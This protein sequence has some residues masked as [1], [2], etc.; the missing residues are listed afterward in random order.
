MHSWLDLFEHAFIFLIVPP[1]FSEI[2][3]LLWSA[4]SINVVGFSNLIDLFWRVSDSLVDFKS[5]WSRLS[6]L[7]RRSFQINP[8]F[9]NFVFWAD[10]YFWINWIFRHVSSASGQLNLL[11]WSSFFCCLD[12]LGLSD[13]QAEPV[14]IFYSV[15]F[16][17][18]FDLFELIRIFGSGKIASIEVFK[19]VKP[20]RPVDSVKS[21]FPGI[22]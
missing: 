19:P 12:I 6:L 9:S 16:F 10:R 14:G 21:S 4:T 11:Y 13:L 1:A 15:G 22:N 17:D 5:F 18:S 7:N 20:V 8:D 3:P 2:L